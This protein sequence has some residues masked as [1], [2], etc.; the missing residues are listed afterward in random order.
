MIP[1]LQLSDDSDRAKVESL[2]GALR[3]DPAEV[4][5]N[6]GA[7]AKH[8]AT[9]QAILADVAKRGDAAIVDL[10]KKFD[11]PDFTAAQI[12]VTPDEMRAAAERV[13]ADQLAAIRRSIAQVR[14]YQQH[15]MPQEPPALKRVGVELGMRFTPIET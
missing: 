12:R 13:P 2:L 5:L 10:S 8:V 11:D 7:R 15:V 3:L 1:T 9:V 14:E 6:Q 4:A